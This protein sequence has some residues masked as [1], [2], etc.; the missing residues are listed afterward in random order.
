MK[1]KPAHEDKVPIYV[2]S[3]GH[4]YVKV[5][6]LLQSSRVQNTL[7]EMAEIAKKQKQRQAHENTQN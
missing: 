1:K 2:T 3:M 6:E 4:R 5:E 7:R